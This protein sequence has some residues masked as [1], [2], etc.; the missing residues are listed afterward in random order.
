MAAIII[1]SKHKNSRRV[2]KPS[3]A[4]VSLGL[5]T[6]KSKNSCRNECKH[7]LLMSE[8]LL[9]ALSFKTQRI[10]KW[11]ERARKLLVDPDLESLAGEARLDELSMEL[12]RLWLATAHSFSDQYLKSPPEGLKKKLPTGSS[13]YY[14]YERLVYPRNLE[15]RCPR[16]R[17]TPTDWQAEHIIFRSGM[18]AIGALLQVFG[19]VLFNEDKEVIKMD[20]FA[21]YYETTWM[22]DIFSSPQFFY[23]RLASQKQMFASIIRQEANVL[24]LEPVCY[25][26]ELVALDLEGLFAALGQRTTPPKMIIIDTTIIGHKFPLEQFLQRLPG[27]PTPLVVVLNSGLKLDQ[28]GLELANVGLLTMLCMNNSPRQE[29]LTKRMTK[30]MRQNRKVLG[31]GLSVDEMAIL[32][33]PWFLD[34]ER[35][36]NHCQ[37]VFD[38]NRLL[39]TTLAPLIAK[40]SGVF[41]Q[42]SHPSLCHGAQW[43]WAEAPFVVMHFPP[44][45]DRAENHKLLV[46]I[47]LRESK[48]RNLGLVEGMSFGFRGHRFEIIRPKDVLSPKGEQKG[49]LKVAMGRRDGPGKNGVIQLLV[50]LA[51]QP[52]WAAMAN[53]YAA[54]K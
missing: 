28:E 8:Q 40:N 1:S 20:L 26:W 38:N 48:S 21:G 3:V 5:V 49:L 51:R 25:D 31:N 19:Q 32:D 9:D 6:G 54:D 14:H 12:R 41:S 37:G 17:P 36:A 4:K 44:E 43:S 2:K 22:M 13:P 18:S 29:K 42:I 30:K 50:E 45:Q 47:I 33:T 35:F 15:K 52:D 11:Q 23:R 16:Y 27:L 53:T 24:F 7:L 39:A 34:P 46:E 10:L